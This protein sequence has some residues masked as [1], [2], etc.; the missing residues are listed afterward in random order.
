V[1]LKDDEVEGSYKDFG[2]A[3]N[4]IYNFNEENWKDVTTC[5]TYAYIQHSFVFVV[6]WVVVRLNPLGTSVTIWP[7]AKIPDDGW[8]CVWNSRWNDWQGKPKYSE[9]TCPSETLSAIIPTLRDPCSNPGRRGGTSP[10]NRLSYGAAYIEH[11]F[12][13]VLNIR[14]EDVGWIRLESEFSSVLFW[15]RR[16]TFEFHKRQR[17]FLVENPLVCQEEI[18]SVYSVWHVIAYIGRA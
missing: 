9:K 13:L 5:E 8:W 14:H 4:Y 10:T 1:F 6:S 18:R 3:D 17:G 15:T 7:I 16:Q 2:S 11:K 12:K